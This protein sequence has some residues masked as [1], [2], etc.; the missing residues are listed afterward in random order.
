M[1]TSEPP[2]DELIHAFDARLLLDE[3]QEGVTEVRVPHLVEKLMETRG[4]TF[5]DARLVVYGLIETRKLTLTPRYTVP[6]EKRH[7]HLTQVILSWG[8]CPMCDEYHMSHPRSRVIV[9]GSHDV[10]AWTTAYH[11][12]HALGKV[13]PYTLVHTGEGPVSADAE[14]VVSEHGLPCEEHRA[15]WG[16][17]GK[18]AGIVRDREMIAAGADL[19]L[20]L[21]VNGDEKPS[22][23]AHMAEAAGINTRRIQ[24]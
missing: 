11:L 9:V 23:F 3:V 5:E 2:V 20:V 6:V 19:C 12:G 16:S 14:Q 17:L 4:L 10:P 15:D 18:E 13:G 24:L 7:N 21:I 22:R 1:G 8:E